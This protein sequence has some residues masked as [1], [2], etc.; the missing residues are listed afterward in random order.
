MGVMQHHYAITGTSA[1]FVTEDYQYHLAKAMSENNV[2][3]YKELA[4]RLLQDT[5]IKTE[6]LSTCVGANNSTV[7]EC[8]ISDKE[9]Q[10]QKEFVVL[11]HN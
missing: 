11:V 8:P 1:Q 5:G 3:Y 4:N 10:N 2:V 7:I 6:N 9:N